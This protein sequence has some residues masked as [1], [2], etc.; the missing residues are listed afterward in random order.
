MKKRKN[1]LKERLHT[2]VQKM[3]DE[4]ENS[5]GEWV[6]QWSAPNGLPCNYVSKKYY[7][8]FNMFHLSMVAYAEGYEAPYWLTFNQVKSL[9]GRVKK[10]EKA[11]D[12]FFYKILTRIEKPDEDQT[13]GEFEI[14]ERIPLL[15]MYKVFNI[16]QTEGIDYELP[17]AKINDNER[18]QNAEEFI[19]RTR[20][21][22]VYSGDIACYIHSEDLIRMPKLEYFTDSDAYYAT[23]LHELTHWSGHSARLDRDRPKK[24]GDDVYAFE[25]LIAELGAVFL[26]SHLCI[27]IEKNR[28]P[29]YLKS[30]VE[31]LREDPH[32]LWKAASR[33]Q[34]AF[35][36][37]LK[38]VSADATRNVR[39]D[40]G[41]AA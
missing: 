24:W 15:R 30:W 7:R 12:V 33:A 3:I 39:H 4:M 17:E 37:L 9:G 26:C 18:Y 11:T 8:G 35:D 34:E 28:H 19:D 38:L 41:E 27:N 31:G 36:Y 10:G 21:K 6:K 13:D 22:I 1:G 32:I 2:L 25:E 20:A 29:E 16:E 23:L 5:T 14:K 40:R